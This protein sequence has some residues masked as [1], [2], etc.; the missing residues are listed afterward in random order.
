MSSNSP[1]APGTPGNTALPTA[2]PATSLSGSGPSLLTPQ[3]RARLVDEI[4]TI[5]GKLPEHVKRPNRQARR[6][7]AKTGRSKQWH[8]LVAKATQAV[9]REQN[10]AHAIKHNAY[11]QSIPDDPAWD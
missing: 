3:G 7:M 11:I 1:F 10:D 6:R 9:L 8:H 5:N 2:Q 4:T